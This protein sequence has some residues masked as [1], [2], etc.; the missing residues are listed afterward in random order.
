MAEFVDKTSARGPQTINTNERNDGTTCTQ[1]L[2]T[3]RQPTSKRWHT[4]THYTYTETQRYICRPISVHIYTY[5]CIY[6]CMNIYTSLKVHAYSDT[7]AENLS[8]WVIHTPPLQRQIF[9]RDHFHR[10]CIVLYCIV[11]YCIVLYCIHFYSASHSKSL[12][13][14]FPIAAIDTDTEFARRS[15][16]H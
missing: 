7:F 6:I 11:L 5:I 10:A 16:M 14:A 1:N 8:L 9:T 4:L 15:A 12:S 3:D 13:E 2:W